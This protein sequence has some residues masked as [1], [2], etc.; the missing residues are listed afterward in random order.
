MNREE[1]HSDITKMDAD[2]NVTVADGSNTPKLTFAYAPMVE[3]DVYVFDTPMNVTVLHEDEDITDIVTFAANSCDFNLHDEDETI[4]GH[5]RL[6]ETGEDLPE[7]WV[8]VQSGIELPE[9]GGMGT[10]IFYGLGGILVVGAV[11]LLVRRKAANA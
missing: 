4:S 10:K 2:G 11:I 9:T 3:E 7:F 8:H 5:K 6:T 1:T